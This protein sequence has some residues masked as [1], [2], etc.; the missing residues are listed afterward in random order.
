[1]GNRMIRDG[2]SWSL[3]VL[4]VM[5]VADAQ[6]QHLWRQESQT[7]GQ[8]WRSVSVGADGSQVSANL[9]GSGGSLT[10]CVAGTATGGPVLV[11]ESAGAAGRFG[12]A[13][14]ARARDLHADLSFYPAAGNLTMAPVLRATSSAFPG[15][16]WT[17]NFPPIAGASTG[18]P[19]GLHVSDNGNRIAAW[20]YDQV[21]HRAQVIATDGV[22]NLLANLQ[23]TQWV[24]PI[25]SAQNAAGDR[26][27][28]TVSGGL[29]VLNVVAGTAGPIL[30]GTGSP[31]GGL[32][33]S[34]DGSIVGF[35]NTNGAVDL[36]RRDPAGNYAYWAT[37]PG[38][39]NFVGSVLALSG[40][41]SVLAAGYSGTLDPRQQ[42]VRIVSLTGTTPTTVHE[43]LLT[44]VGTGLIA[45][46]DLSVSETGDFV[47]VATTGDTTNTM[48]ELRVY[49]RSATGGYDRSTFDLP[50]S[51][52]DV[53]ISR[54]STTLAVVSASGHV[55]QSPQFAGLD[56]YDLESDVKVQGI[57]HA[58]GV[59]ICN[60]KSSPNARTILLKSNAV[61]ASPVSVGLAQGALFLGNPVIAG[62]APADAAGVAH[63]AFNVPGGTEI[64]RTLYFQGMRMGDRQLTKNWA[65]ITVVP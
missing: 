15:A 12:I 22:G 43:D 56:V 31:S 26:L 58:N 52:Y 65:S 50:G 41:G 45:L 16:A 38:Y 46:S 62:M 18:Q 54:N 63:F 37:I 13:A 25:E 61:L 27:F 44:G 36:F 8:C 57:P 42:R 14:S 7:P 28:L 17:I 10:I 30:S 51:A 24:Q 34:G 47:A 2:V 21:T 35:T 3:G 40:D 23:L 33:L 11:T 39:A 9:E 48:P 55:S 19:A 49:R 6:I 32:A 59:V 20:W 4:S 60:V 29:V 5:G 64:G 53:E 1:M